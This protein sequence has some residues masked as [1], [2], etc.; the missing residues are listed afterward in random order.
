MA[1]PLRATAIDSTPSRT[2]SGIGSRWTAL[3]AV[4]ARARRAP[5]SNA[6]RRSADTAAPAPVE[7]ARAG[8]RVRAAGAAVPVG[9]TS[10]RRPGRPAP[11]VPATRNPPT[12]PGA[13][14]A[15]SGTGCQAAGPCPLLCT[16]VSSDSAGITPEPGVR[17]RRNHFDRGDLRRGGAYRILDGQFQGHRG[18]RAALATA[19]ELQP[20]D[21]R[22]R[23]R[24]GCTSPPCEPR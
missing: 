6:R 15:S 8:Q 2:S 4:D 23:P 10:R 7:S 19:G 14:S 21:R 3:G 1:P 12:S 13:S 20:H 24:A 18:R 16:R 11:C 22:R 17:F 9:V 5:T